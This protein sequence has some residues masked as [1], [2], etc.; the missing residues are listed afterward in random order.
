[1]TGRRTL[2]I[3][4]GVGIVGFL[5]IASIAFRA[6]PQPIIEIKGETLWSITLI[7]GVPSWLGVL[8]IRNTLFTA[9]FIVGFL[10]IFAFLSGRG[11][12]WLPKGGGSSERNVPAPHNHDAG[13]IA[14][15]SHS[16]AVF[17]AGQ[18]KF[19]PVG[20]CDFS[21]KRDGCIERHPGTGKTHRS[22][23]PGR[24]RDALSAKISPPWPPS[25]LSAP[26][27]TTACA[28]RRG[29]RYQSV[30]GANSPFRPMPRLRHGRR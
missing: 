9:W 25:T 10:V 8:E 6:I 5:L 20:S 30:P 22:R 1:M 17:M 24:T 12:K 4:A 2:I 27:V 15:D 29:T 13:L 18:I 26:A 19:E 23:L 14:Q 28:S 7:P 3:L 16:I 21:I 11:L